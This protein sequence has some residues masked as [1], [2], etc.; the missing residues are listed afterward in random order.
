MG[1]PCHI[2]VRQDGE[3]LGRR[4]A[5]DSRRV[6]ISHSARQGG[7]HRLEGLVRWATAVR[8][9]QENPEVSLV[10]VSA[11]KLV[12]EDRPHE[13]IVEESCRPIDDVKGLGLRV[14]GPHSA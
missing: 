3:E 4:A 2:G 14:V 12:L 5:K 9:D 10:A 8:L 1:S 11:R 6:D 7:G 13:A